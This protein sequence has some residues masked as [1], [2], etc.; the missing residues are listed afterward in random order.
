MTKQFSK[1]QTFT[2]AVVALVLIVV[3]VGLYLA[4]SPNTERLRRFDDQR[5]QAL[6]N[7]AGTVDNFYLQ[8][9]RLP[10][11]LDELTIPTTQKSGY[12]GQKPYSYYIYTSKD[13]RTGAP[14]EYRPVDTKIYEVCADF[15]QEK[16]NPDQNNGEYPRVPYPAYPVDSGS[17]FPWKHG[18]GRTCFSLNAEVRTSRPSCGLRNPCAAGQTCALLPDTTSAVCVPEGKECLAANCSSTCALTESYPVQVHCAD[19][20]P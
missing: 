1:L 16:I 12:T 13:P 20:T 17:V 6:E 9:N 8:E 10:N 18:V 5:V 15:D 2:S 19:V 14:Y 3:G 7:I 11:S 4:G